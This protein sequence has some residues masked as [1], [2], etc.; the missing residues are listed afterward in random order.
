MAQKKI[1]MACSN[2]WTSVFQVGSHHLA[3]E[4]LKLGYEVAFIS[5]PISPFHLLNRTGLKARF[6]LYHSGGIKQNNLWAYAPATLFPPHSK[7]LLRTEWVHRH[8]HELTFPSVVR[9]AHE[10][11]FGDVDIL[12]F[13]TAIQSF[14]LKEIRARKTVFRIADQNSG[15]KKATPAFINLEKELIQSVDLVVCTAKTL[16]DSIKGSKHLPNGVPLAH[17]AKPTDIPPEYQSLTKPIALYVGAID[18]WFDFALIKKLALDLPHV[19][20]VL[21]GPIKE[22][23]FRN[24]SN[25][26]LLGPKPYDSIPSYLQHAN[27]GLIPFDVEN[28]PDLIHSVNPLKLYEYMASGL[29]VVATRW[30]ELENIASPAHLCRTS[31]EF[32]QGILDAVQA[33]NSELNRAYAKNLDWS[34]RCSQLIDHLGL[35][36]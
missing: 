16:T 8:W 13:D 30:R 9:K 14:W 1:L 7:P 29:P 22:N 3:R 26:H 33:P 19:S 12:Y 24:I 11:G 10:N 2:P 4:F 23:P 21:I 27:V 17:F 31:E 6:D 25:I 35:R 20:F 18:Y 36:D 15:F 32:K 34:H 28:Y 5:D